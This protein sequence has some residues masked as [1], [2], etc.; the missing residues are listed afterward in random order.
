MTENIIYY[1]ICAFFSLLGLGGSWYSRH[2]Y[3]LAKV[4][5]L[6]LATAC[7]AY[8]YFQQPELFLYLDITHSL[9]WVN[10][11]A[12]QGSRLRM[13]VVTI[14]FFTVVAYL[15]CF[16]HVLIATIKRITNLGSNAPAG[17][18]GRTGRRC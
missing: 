9:A 3:Y 7:T 15:V 11:M 18:D 12:G 2:S 5:S 13:A 10:E 16:E 17:L 8:L 1:G 6:A 4:F 14:I